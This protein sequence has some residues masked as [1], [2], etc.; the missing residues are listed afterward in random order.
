[1][2]F[3]EQQDEACART[4]QLLLFALTVAL[5]V[6][7]INA[8]QAWT[9]RRVTVGFSKYPAYFFAVN[10]VMTLAALCWA[11]GDFQLARR[12]CKAGTTRGRTVGLTDRDAKA[13]WFDSHPPLVERICRIHGRAMPVLADCQKENLADLRGEILRKDTLK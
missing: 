13:P 12:W 3:L 8:A 6:L 2:R 7:G 9:W 1:M 5:L 11:A 4:R 10:T